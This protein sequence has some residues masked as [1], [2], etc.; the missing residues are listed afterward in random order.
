[1]KDV[2]FSVTYPQVIGIILRLNLPKA[3]FDEISFHLIFRDSEALL[4]RTDTE[5]RPVKHCVNG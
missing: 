3:T 1:M 4:T 5:I 2:L